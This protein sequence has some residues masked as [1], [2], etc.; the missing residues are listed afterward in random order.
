MDKHM[1]IEKVLFWY[2]VTLSILSLIAW[3]IILIKGQ[4]FGMNY[5]Y[6]T[7]LYYQHMHF[8][9]F[10]GYDGIFIEFIKS[11]K[12]DT[13]SLFSY[14][15][16][17]AYGY[18]FFYYISPLGAINVYLLSIFSSVCTSVVILG[19]V[20][21]HSHKAK[22]FWVIII[23]TMLTSYPVMFLIDRG[24]IEGILWMFILL[25]CFALMYENFLVAGV[26]FAVAASMK[27]YPIV[28]LLLLWSKH[29]YKEF[30][31]SVFILI[32]IT[33]L[34]AYGLTGSLCETFDMVFS[35]Q[36]GLVRTNEPLQDHFNST[37]FSHSLFSAIKQLLFVLEY[38]MNRLIFISYAMFTI[39]IL[40]FLYLSRICRLPLINQIFTLTILSLFLPY[41]SYDYTLIHLY[42]PWGLFMVFLAYDAESSGFT[43]K[44]AL[45]ILIPCAII[46]TPQSYLIIEG[47]G[48]FGGQVKALVLLYLL[49]VVLKNPMPSDT[50]FKESHSKSMKVIR[51]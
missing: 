45:N 10:T 17:A 36:S 13:S 3:Q 1:N 22:M 5:P 28:F 27:L 30:V 34:A 44:Q 32:L 51:L 37:G 7:F 19:Y 31:M 47:I 8:N 35:G 39:T 15:P 29:K 38:P 2:M 14:F 20:L 46:F 26:C 24:N 23:L 4:F 49:I 6:N 50:L 40:I 11:G 43:T 9:D 16:M 33:I 21:R 41:F 42:I 18:I 12:F 48:G 25:G